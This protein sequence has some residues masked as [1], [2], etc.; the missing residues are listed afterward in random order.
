[1]YELGASRPG[2]LAE[3]RPSLVLAPVHKGLVLHWASTGH[4]S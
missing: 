1:M 4:L 3:L 2:S